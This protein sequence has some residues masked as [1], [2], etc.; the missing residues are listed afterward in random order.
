MEKKWKSMKIIEKFKYKGYMCREAQI[1]FK[2]KIISEQRDG[3][4]TVGHFIKLSNNVTY[5][6]SKNDKFIKYENGSIKLL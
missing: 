5:L 2:N 6:P 4:A 3:C 1:F